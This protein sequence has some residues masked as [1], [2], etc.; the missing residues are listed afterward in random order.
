MA[1]LTRHG[2]MIRQDW[3]QQETKIARRAMKKALE[4]VGEEKTDERD[5]GQVAIIVRRQ[6]KDR[7]RQLVLEKYV[8]VV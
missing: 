4:G 7:E 6:C 1:L 8:S 5:D 2:P 3:T